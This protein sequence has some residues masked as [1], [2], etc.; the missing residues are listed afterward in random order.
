VPFVPPGAAITIWQEWP[1][2]EKPA[3][4]WAKNQH[5]AAHR[6][7]LGLFKQNALRQ[8]LAVRLPGATVW[9]SPPKK[10]ERQSKLLEFHS[11]R[12]V[13]AGL[14]V[15]LRKLRKSIRNG[16]TKNSSSFSSRF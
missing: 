13:A 9:N 8:G 1:R 7:W 15:C 16:G 5:R 12:Q 2:H 14:N 10:S 11:S 6:Q 3:A 4:Q